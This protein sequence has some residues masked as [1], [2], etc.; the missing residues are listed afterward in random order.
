MHTE[1]VR[2]LLK[3]YNAHQDT[4]ILTKTLLYLQNITVHTKASQHIL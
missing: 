3:Y 1:T 2:C 4:T